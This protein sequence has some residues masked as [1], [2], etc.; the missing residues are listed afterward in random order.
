M[1]VSVTLTVQRPSQ[2]ETVSELHIDWGMKSLLE[3]TGDNTRI[4]RLRFITS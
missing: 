4:E 2:S 3:K 1:A